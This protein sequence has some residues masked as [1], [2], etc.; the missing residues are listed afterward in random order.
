MHI[1]DDPG[2]AIDALLADAEILSDHD[3]SQAP[4][5][6]RRIARA[7]ARNRPDAAVCPAS[8]SEEDDQAR[9]QLDLISAQV[10]NTPQ[11]ATWLSRLDNTR[12]IE[13]EGA[14]VFACL[15]H[16]AGREDGAQFWWQFAAGSGS[17]AAATCL[18]YHHHRNAELRDADYWR[19]QAD[20]LLARPAECNP[21]PTQAAEHPLLP[22]HVAKDL[23][24]QCSRGVQPR[25]PAELEEVINQL[26]IEYDDA[27][28]GEIPQPSPLLPDV[29]GAHN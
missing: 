11:A 19:E 6:A 14:L 1:T 2:S 8:D 29:L 27:D 25:L 9:R 10:L 13:P 21:T 28:F 16:L 17:H 26:V 7:A 22:D 5:A 3:H 23:L 20:R 24:A 4:T 12:H 15:L 18:S